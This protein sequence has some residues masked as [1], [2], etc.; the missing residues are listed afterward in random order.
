MNGYEIKHAL[1]SDTITN[2]WFTDVY[3][4][5]QIK[6]TRYPCAI[7]VN[8]DDSSQKGTHW[9]PMFVLNPD[10]IEVFDS[11]G[12]PPWELGAN[13]SKFVSKFVNIFYNDMQFQNIG[14]TVCGAYS[15]YY[16]WMKCQDFT[17]C[18]IQSIL[19]RHTDRDLQMYQ[20]MNVCKRNAR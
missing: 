8:I 13:I 3:A 20:Q 11:F 17:L 2:M 9:I 10:T 14:T 18:E 7:V 16:I 5:D 12:R 4:S 1:Q 19:R 6:V 15:I